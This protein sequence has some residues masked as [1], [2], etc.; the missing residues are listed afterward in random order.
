[1]GPFPSRSCETCECN[2]INNASKEVPEM[3]GSSETIL[4]VILVG[5][6]MRDGGDGSNGGSGVGGMSLS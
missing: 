6:E 5:G 1:M 3:I 2:V 4:T